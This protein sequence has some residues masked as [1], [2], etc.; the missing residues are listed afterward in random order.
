[1]QT[2]PKISKEKT[3]KIPW[4]HPN[5]SIR[6]SKIV[7]IFEDSTMSL[8]SQINPQT[9]I[10]SGIRKFS[11]NNDG[12]SYT[13]INNRSFKSIDNNRDAIYIKRHLLKTRGITS[14]TKYI[15]NEAETAIKFIDELEKHK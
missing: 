5:K 13:S 9:G 10:F 3:S 11:Q 15:N 1:M 12:S 14:F 4:Y 2:T 8:K 6:T 7:N